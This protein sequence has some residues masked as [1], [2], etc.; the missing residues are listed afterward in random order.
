M[1]HSRS[2]PGHAVLVAGRALVSNPCDFIAATAAP[3]HVLNSWPLI[4]TAA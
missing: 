2:Q 1:A 4:T 3:G